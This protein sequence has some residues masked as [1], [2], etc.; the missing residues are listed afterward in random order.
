MMMIAM[1]MM[2]IIIPVDVAMTS[3]NFLGSMPSFV[4]SARASEVP[5]IWIANAKLLHSLVTPPVPGP[6]YCD[7][8]NNSNSNSNNNGDDNHSNDDNNDDNNDDTSTMYNF[9]THYFQ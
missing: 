6:C 1:M 9:L 2:V 8:N 7:N 5:I 4:P 3:D